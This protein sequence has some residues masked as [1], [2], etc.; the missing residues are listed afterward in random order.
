MDTLSLGAQIAIYFVVGI[1]FLFI[2]FIAI[3]AMFYKKIAQ[4]QALIKTGFGGTAVAFDKGMYVI[5][6]LH[7]VDIMDISLK[8][9]E[10]ENT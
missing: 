9:I 3:N 6:V 8:K 5:P 10:I 7:K 1:I 4:G 2:V